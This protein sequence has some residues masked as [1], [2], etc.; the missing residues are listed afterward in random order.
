[1]LFAL[2]IEKEYNNGTC[3][4]QD[5]DEV[6]KDWN[7]FYDEFCPTTL[8]TN[9][10]EDFEELVEVDEPEEDDDIFEGFDD[11]DEEESYEKR[12]WD[13]NEEFPDT[14]SFG[15]YNG[16]KLKIYF[17]SATDFMGIEKRVPCLRLEKDG[18]CYFTLT[19]NFGEF[20]GQM[21]T[22]YIDTN[23]NSNVERFLFENHIGFPTAFTKHS[24]Y[25]VY[26]LYVI[27]PRLIEKLS[28]DVNAYLEDFNY[29]F[30]EL[31]TL[32]TLIEKFYVCGKAISER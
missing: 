28:P 18:E 10:G 11:F 32:D 24:G 1:M 27:N 22:A 15:G 25:C 5:Y 14:Y 2:D 30:E 3:S 16:L 20:I 6:L 12:E 13:R 23:N 7:E 31:P 9:D 26:P 19:T 4:K 17:Y 21:C 29:G 8:K